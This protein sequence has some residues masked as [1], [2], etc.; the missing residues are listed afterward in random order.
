MAISGLFVLMFLHFYAVF[1]VYNSFVKVLTNIAICS[2]MLLLG[3]MWFMKRAKKSFAIICVLYL[4]IFSFGLV[5]CASTEYVLTVSGSEYLCEELHETYKAGEQVTVKTKIYPYKGTKVMLDTELL[6]GVKNY[7]DEYMTFTFAMPAHDATLDI[8]SF[9]GFEEP[10]L[11]GYHV[12][13]SDNNGPIANLSQ[14]VDSEDAIAYYMVPQYDSNGTN[15]VYSFNNGAKV[16][17]ETRF[18]ISKSNFQL[19]S[20]LYFT[21]E[22]VGTVMHFDLVYY[23]YNRQEVLT[24]K[25]GVGHMI[26]DIGYSSISQPQNLFDT[27][28]D[29]QKKEY[30]EKFDSIVKLNMVYID[31]LT[32][33]KVL[34]YNANGDLIKTTDIAKSGGDQ[35]YIASE[36]CEY[37]IVQEEYTVMNGESIGETYRMRS[38]INKSPLVD[39]K[40]LKYPR[41]DGLI[42]PVYLSVKW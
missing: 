31:Y 17:A 16:F 11:Y 9:E 34:E 15:M 41:G 42:S 14:P 19:E 38:L 7:Q 12:T 35:E 4:I 8:T 20:T 39:G 27:R 40:V 28:F 29:S 22:L 18:T 33:V 21:H 3:G 2:I 32:S 13:F 5:S 26:N 25:S 10:L 23:D 1:G 24:A 30:T 6:T 37:V 36:N